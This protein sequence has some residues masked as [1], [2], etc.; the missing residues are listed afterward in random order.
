MIALI[1]LLSFLIGSIP[2]GFLVGLAKGVDIR[3]V[4]SGNIGA[5][6]T[7]RELGAKAG[8]LV[9]V[10]DVAKGVLPSVLVRSLMSH[11]HSADILTTHVLLSGV[12][13][14]LG[15][16]FSPFLGFKGGKGVATGLGAVIGSSPIVGIVG[17][18]VFVIVVSVTKIVSVSSLSGCLAV[19]IA[20]IIVGQPPVVIGV[21]VLVVVFVFVRHIPNFKRLLKGQEPKMSFKKNP[22]DREDE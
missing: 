10:L 2:F 16:S 19:V 21:F 5:T 11:E 3:K 1:Y 4:G 13:S 9:F 17:F 15:H 8:I 12:V 6:N 14:V 22:K 7:Y 18:L 20:A